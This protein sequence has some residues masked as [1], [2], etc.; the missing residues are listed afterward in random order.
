[1]NVFHLLKPYP[2]IHHRVADVGQD[3]ADDIQ[4][5]AEKHHGADDGEVLTVDRVDQVAPQAGDTEERFEQ[6]VAQHQGR[7]EEDRRGQDR[8]RGVLQHVAEKY[9]ALADT[10][11]PRRAHVVL[12]HLLQHHGAVEPHASA[13]PIDDADGGRQQDELPGVGAAPVA[14]D[15]AILQEL[16]ENEL[17]AHDIDEIGD[18]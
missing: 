14:G 4:Y 15:R 17:P 1:N 10:L 16:A 11:G 3:G 2:R 12:V 13:Q 9:R 8:D 18:A 7:N 5:R 6:E